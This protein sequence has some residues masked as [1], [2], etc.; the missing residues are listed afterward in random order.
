MKPDLSSM[1]T[2]WQL[3]LDC[4]MFPPS[5]SLG[6]NI[7]GGM[8]WLADYR[9][10]NSSVAKKYVP[11]VPS[12]RPAEKCIRL[13]MRPW[14][15]PAKRSQLALLPAAKLQPRHWKMRLR[16][17]TRG[18]LINMYWLVPPKQRELRTEI[19]ECEWRS[20]GAGQK[21]EGWD[22]EISLCAI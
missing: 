12:E 15:G 17:C 21:E 6:A 13:L 22:V 19:T 1:K 16:N 7:A 14:K 18:I 8:R 2:R 20:D 3:T 11:L 9:F 4:E 10:V 5:V